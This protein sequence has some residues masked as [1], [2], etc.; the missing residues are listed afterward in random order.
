[1]NPGLRI[2]EVSGSPRELGRAHGE[3]L[4]TTIAEGLQ[5]WLEVIATETG[6]RTDD[7]VASFLASTDFL[8]AIETHTPDCLEE[9]RGIAE[10]ARQSFDVMLAYQL[11]DEE[12]WYRDSLA[13]SRRASFH[14]CSAVGIVHEA[15]T[16]LVAQNMDL[17]SHYD[18]T[19]VLLRLRPS[20]GPETMLFSPSGILGTTGLNQEGVAVCVNALPHLRHRTSG[21]PVGFVIRGLLAKRTLADAVTVL[22]AVPHATGQNYL[23]GEP[24]AIGDFECSPG[25]VSEVKPSGSL[26]KHTNHPLANEDIDPE[27]A[28]QAEYRSTTRA[29]LATLERELD[30]LGA[31][32]T[33]DDVARTLSDRAAPVSV[34]RGSDWMTLGS[35]IMELSSEPVLHIAPGPPAD[36]AY[37]EVRF[38]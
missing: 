7:Y 24:G 30:G 20:D 29:R 6:L 11:M 22:Q 5:N 12:W 19:Q 28:G 36:T 14:A 10:G 25:Q 13:M 16:S 17:P 1:V 37:S 23:L 8:T 18:G 26:I 31:T 4:R 9:V 21:L 34:P 32:A 2:V 3:E 33:V 35:V 38:S 15:G 27:E